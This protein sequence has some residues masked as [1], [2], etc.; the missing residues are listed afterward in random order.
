MLLAEG[1]TK[2]VVVGQAPRRVLC[3]VSLTVEAGEGV[4]GARTVRERQAFRTNLPRS[5]ARDGRLLVLAVLS[6]GDVYR[7]LLTWVGGAW[8]R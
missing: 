7:W 6:S 3:G 2:T 4:A 5:S 8:A 1:L